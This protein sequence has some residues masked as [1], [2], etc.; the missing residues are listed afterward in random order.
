[1]W[2]LVLLQIAPIDDDQRLGHA[3]EQHPRQHRVD[4]LGI[5]AKMG[6]AQEPIGTLDAM[7][8]VRPAAEAS[9]NLGQSQ[10]WA[11]DCRRHGPK[12]HGQAPTVDAGQQ[13][14]NTTL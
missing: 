10:P 3:R 6:V 7:A 5:T 11:A 4:V 1:M 13:R 14:R 12:Q 8:Q 9:A 2:R